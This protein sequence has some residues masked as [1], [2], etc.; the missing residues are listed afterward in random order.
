MKAT[1]VD[2]V[3]SN[4]QPKFS[5]WHPSTRVGFRF[6]F[7]YFGLY[8]LVSHI[9]VYLV[10]LP[11]T[12]PGQGPGTLWPMLDLTSWT[13][14]HIFGMTTPLVYTGNSRDTNFFWV[15]LF[16]VLVIASIAT[17]AWSVLD[18]RRE[19][20]ATLH[21]W[22]RV[23]LRFAVAAQMLYF[24]MVKVIPTQF[25][26]PSLVT[27]IAPVGNLSLQGLLWTSIGASQPY[28]IFT[29]I[30]EVLGGLLL[31]APRTTMLGATLCLASMIQ[32]FI[33]NMTYD[34][35]VKILSFQLALM[36]FF[37]LAP[38]F[39]R[40]ANVFFR[41]DPSTEHALF[42]TRHANKIALAVQIAFG[43]YLLGVYA[44]IGRTF[45]YTEGGG[46]SPKSLL[47]GIWNVEE[48]AIDGELRPPQVNEYDRRWRRVIFDGPQWIFFQRTDDS[49]VRYGVNIDV[50]QNTLALTKGH[51]RTWHSNFTF[52]RPDSDRLLLDGHMDGHR[53]N[54]KLQLVE[55]DTFR[56]LNSRFRWVRPPDPDTE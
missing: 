8:C 51:S 5:R 21:K 32:V 45:W 19:N 34:V 2:P 10:V 14:V 22:F 47:Y 20:Y 35:G 48:L 29:G 25:P 44:N 46:G 9:L 53:I 4:E 39:P 6:G 1:H 23:V 31:L 42:P 36:S 56:L 24:G 3:E 26:A 37:L 11:N 13:A 52:E 33:L 16:L 55:F 7:A 15:Q 30:V 43:I 17:I 28:Q 40:L 41:N 18:R 38:D 49:F 27:L 12:L 50:Q 54:M